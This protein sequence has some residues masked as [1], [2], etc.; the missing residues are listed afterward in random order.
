MIS[1]I[2][3]QQKNS[4]HTDASNDF[5]FTSL[6][7]NLNYQKYIYLLIFKPYLALHVLKPADESKFLNGTS[8]KG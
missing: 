2:P 1:K 5:V 6:C 7:I 8:K 3:N 4:K